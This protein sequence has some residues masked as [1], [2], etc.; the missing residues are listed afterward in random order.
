MP[1]T[2]SA[3]KSLKQ[4]IKRNLRNRAARSLVK[5]S[6]KKVR[7]ALQ[8]N[9]KEAAHQAFSQAVP[10]MDKAVAK[11]IIHKNAA[12]RHKSRLARQLRS[13]KGTPSPS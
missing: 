7:I 10:I 11:G 8:E 1:I 13:L 12:A 3:I 6:I 9:Q 2:K 4:S 5:T